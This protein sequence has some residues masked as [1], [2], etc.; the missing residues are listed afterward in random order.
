MA[1]PKQNMVKPYVEKTE[2][3]SNKVGNLVIDGVD[4]GKISEGGFNALKNNTLSSYT[5][6]DDEEKATLDNFVSNYKITVTDSKGKNH[7]TIS[8]NTLLKMQEKPNF[9]ITPSN[10]SA[11][12]VNA[13]KNYEIPQK[14]AVP[15]A[16][17]ALKQTK[18][19]LRKVRE[20][21]E[22]FKKNPIERTVVNSYINAERQYQRDK[23][24][25]IAIRA[26]EIFKEID[27]GD[28]YGTYGAD[29]ALE[30]LVERKIS[31]DE[32]FKN[33]SNGTLLGM[34]GDGTAIDEDEK[35]VHNAK[36]EAD[37]SEY[38]LLLYVNHLAENYSLSYLYQ[39]YLNAESKLNANSLEHPGNLTETYSVEQL[40]DHK[41]IP[42]VKSMLKDAFYIRKE[43]HPEDE[44]Y[45]ELEYITKHFKHSLDTIVTNLSN[46]TD[47]VWGVISFDMDSSHKRIA[48][49]SKALKA[50]AQAIES[51]AP[52]SRGLGAMRMIGQLPEQAPQ[53]VLTA[54]NPVAGLAYSAVNAFGGAYGDAAA[55]G[56]GIKEST[57]YGIMNA[58]VEVALEKLM[59]DKVFGGKSILGK[60]MSKFINKTVSSPVARGVIGYLADSAGEGAEEVIS[61]AISPYIQKISGVEVDSPEFDDYVNNFVAGMFN[62]IVYGGASRVGQLYKNTD[63][64]SIDDFTAQSNETSEEITKKVGT[65]IKAY[66]NDTEV[67]YASYIDNETL[68]MNYELPELSKETDVNYD[69]DL[70][71]GEF[72]KGDFSPKNS[73]LFHPK[74]VENREAFRLVTGIELPKTKAGTD[75]YLLYYANKNALHIN[76][77]NIYYNKFFNRKNKNKLDLYPSEDYNKHISSIKN[78]ENIHTPPEYYKTINEKLEGKTHEKTGVSFIRKEIDI[79]GKTYSLVVPEFESCYDATISPELYYK[80]DR[81]QFKECNRQLLE[82][83]NNNADIRKKFSEVQLEQLRNGETPDGYTWHHSEETGKLKLVNKEIHKRTG[84]TGGRAIWGGGSKYR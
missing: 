21:D 39:M 47:F 60:K 45:N 35:I 23:I 80:R 31:A 6:L 51:K 4:Y 12:F 84:H 52:L 19:G 82:A 17:T 36:I 2:N 3:T 24:E 43:T 66:A 76:L 70:A 15:P 55:S 73:G 65:N 13:V 58:A 1:L 14:S 41:S 22:Y 46:T 9:S 75:M 69:V 71:I 48:D 63:I 33:A 37:A 7:G 61:T 68:N 30:K 42:I 44:I 59:G 8:Y 5:P 10:N 53:V 50:N 32:N 74:N 25:H 20:T 16:L 28:L 18:E 81:V 29:T 11:D 27:V 54:I 83:V 62:S 77:R 79:S 72:Q 64:D 67:N 26:N 78:A 34:A 56:A 40:L 57:A 38:A 49:R